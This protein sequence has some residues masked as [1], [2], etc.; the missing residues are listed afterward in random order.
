MLSLTIFAIVLTNFQ[1][2]IGGVAEVGGRAISL[3]RR[4]QATGGT[5]ETTLPL[6]CCRCLSCQ[7]VNDS[8]MDWPTAGLLEQP[9]CLLV[10][11]VKVNSQH[12]ETVHWELRAENGAEKRP[13]C[14]IDSRAEIKVSGEA[15][16]QSLAN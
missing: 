12:S 7:P 9:A 10:D 2:G 1:Y 8:L 4:R 13:T 14:A 3:F 15:A 16:P 11:I 6:L 5:E